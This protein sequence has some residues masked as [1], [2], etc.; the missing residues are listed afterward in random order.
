[1]A[2]L[3]KTCQSPAGK[4]SYQIPYT[5]ERAETNTPSAERTHFVVEKKYENIQDIELP[6]FKIYFRHYKSTGLDFSKLTLIR[7]LKLFNLPS[8]PPPTRGNGKGRLLGHGGK[9]TCLEIVLWGDSNLHCQD[10]SNSVYQQ[11]TKQESAAAVQSTWQTPHT[12]QQWQL[13]PE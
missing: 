8:I 4:P 7:V 10:T 12:N 13:S 3:G 6:K 9:W 11:T 2:S 1:M 5:S